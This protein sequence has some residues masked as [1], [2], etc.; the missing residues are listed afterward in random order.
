M[1]VQTESMTLLVQFYVISLRL[2]FGTRTEVSK[3][4]SKLAG[5]RK[6]LFPRTI[7]NL[8]LQQRAN[9]QYP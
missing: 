1:F 9:V 4:D 7:M 8:V 3:T 2:R 5:R 6:A